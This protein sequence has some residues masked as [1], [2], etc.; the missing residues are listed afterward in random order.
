MRALL[1]HVIDHGA[2]AQV[3]RA[4][5]LLRQLA[6]HPESMELRTTARALFDAFLHDPH[7]SR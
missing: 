3:A 5:D 4:R 7:L 1:Q 2:P 6:E